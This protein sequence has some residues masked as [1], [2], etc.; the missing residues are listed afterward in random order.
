MKTLVFIILTLAFLLHAKASFTKEL[1]ICDNSG[2]KR[3]FSSKASEI[4]LGQQKIP[5]IQVE[6]TSK[7]DLQNEELLALTEAKLSSGTTFYGQ[8]YITAFLH[9]LGESGAEYVVIVVPRDTWT[10]LGSTSFCQ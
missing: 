1:Q 8:N 3:T 10:L 2:V 9:V 4:I 7:D 6:E 5:I